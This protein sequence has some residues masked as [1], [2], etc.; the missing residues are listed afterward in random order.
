[1]LTEEQILP[2]LSPDKAKIPFHKYYHEAC[3]KAEEIEVHACGEYPS[4][5]IDTARPNEPTIYKDYRK[6]VYESVT[7]TPWEKSA[8]VVKKINKSDN[9]NIVFPDQKGTF[10]NGATLEDYINN[11][12][13]YFDSIRNWCFSFFVDRMLADSNSVLVILPLPK[14]NPLDDGELLRPYPTFYE[15][16]HVYK[17]EENKI[18]VVKSEEK[19]LVRRGDEYVHEGHI[20]ISLDNDSYAIS[21]QIGQ[22]ND[23]KFET[24]IYS[25][26]ITDEYG[27][28]YMPAIQSG[29]VIKE[30]S[31]FERLNDSFFASM[32]PMLNEAVRR[33]SDHQ[34]NMALHLHPDRWEIQDTECRT[35]SGSGIITHKATKQGGA[36]HT[37]TCNTCGG[38][39]RVSFKSPFGVKL[40]KPAV[41]VGM[42]DTVS[43][44]VPAGYIQRPIETI[45]YLEEEVQRDI[46]AALSAINFEWLTVEPGVNS[47]ISKAYD[48]QELNGFIGIIA[49]HLVNN[50]LY[51]II[52]Y[53]NEIRYQYLGST[54][55]S[56]LPS[57]RIPEDFDVV[58]T[59]AIL[60]NIGAA[61]T[62][63]APSSLLNQM[64]LSLSQKEFGIGSDQHKINE[65][66]LEIDPMPN[67]TSDE[68]VLELSSGGCTK[69]QFIVSCQ[70]TSLI[71]EAVKTIT[72]FLDF[73][74]AKQKQIVFALAEAINMQ[75]TSSLVPIVNIDGSSGGQLNTPNDVE[76]EAKAKLK[77]S[78]GG[79]QG[80]LEIQ[81]SVSQGITDYDAAI[82][83]LYEIFG[84]DD[85]TARRILGNPKKQVIPSDGQKA[86]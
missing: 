16:E 76:A 81:A 4:K 40:I 67:K 41:K 51:P 45:A 63:G 30:M 31:H 15:S 32:V 6:E 85:A 72:G 21:T 36:A 53:S 61:K 73:D 24:I 70:I 10:K 84:F 60:T 64:Y 8:N 59:D 18:C 25:N 47:G 19:S 54:R 27:N 26:P 3:E 34:V 23:Y 42:S 55:F 74:Y 68:K 20:F 62:A 37:S 50:I 9:F 46:K 12:F 28:K 57:I 82:S 86:N 79:V 69:I 48:R 2:F 38:F 43:I 29:G 39:G 71:N 80:I 56:N 35:C 52:F 75:N 14:S 22:I 83:L 78:V 65:L 7:T 66:T 1:M 17:F 33:Y 5:L 58:Y 11:S 44:G 77:G 49:S 13:P